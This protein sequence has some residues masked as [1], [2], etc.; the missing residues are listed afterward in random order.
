MLAFYLFAASAAKTAE[1]GHANGTRLAASAQVKTGGTSDLFDFDGMV[2]DA[3]TMAKA[4]LGEAPRFIAFASTSMPPAALKA[5]MDDVPRAG[6]V[7]V[8]QPQE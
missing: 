7:V 1:D 8:A 3:G 2:A 5:M 6:G 4:D